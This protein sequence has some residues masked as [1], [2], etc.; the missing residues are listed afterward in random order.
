[1]LLGFFFY[2]LWDLSTQPSHCAFLPGLRTL[3]TSLSL[4][5]IHAVYMEELR[6]FQEPRPTNFEINGAPTTVLAISC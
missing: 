1:M 6:S 4:L 5:S 3:A 2:T